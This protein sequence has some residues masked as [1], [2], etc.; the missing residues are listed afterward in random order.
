MNHACLS[1]SARSCLTCLA[2]LIGGFAALACGG[3]KQVIEFNPRFSNNV[4]KVP[5]WFPGDDPLT[6]DQRTTLHVRGRPDFIHFWWRADGS[7][8][9]VSDFSGREAEEISADLEDA[10]KGWVY[11][12]DEEVVLFSSDGTQI[13]TRPLQTQ[14]KTVCLLGDPSSRTRARTLDGQIRETWTWVDEGLVITFLDGRE[15]NRQYIQGTG[16][17]TWLNK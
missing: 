3:N 2:A 8:I 13:E 4:V 9:T 5:S 16:S 7:L 14:L 11:L 1:A 10:K 6:A 12:A 17:G 15:V